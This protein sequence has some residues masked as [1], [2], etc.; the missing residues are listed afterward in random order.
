MRDG[1]ENQ[2]YKGSCRR[3]EDVWRY[4]EEIKDNEEKEDEKCE[5][6]EGGRWNWHW[7]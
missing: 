2:F 5:I 6:R 1:W 7:D 3:W 4:E